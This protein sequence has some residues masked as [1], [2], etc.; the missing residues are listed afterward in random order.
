MNKARKN[1]QAVVL[2]MDAFIYI[3]YIIY[4]KWN[5]PSYEYVTHVVGSVVT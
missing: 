5:A 1:N 2:L 3:I 4:Y